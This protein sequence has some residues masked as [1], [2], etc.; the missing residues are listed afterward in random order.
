MVCEQT[1]KGHGNGTDIG[2]GDSKGGC[3]Q[4]DLV[5]EVSDLVWIEDHEP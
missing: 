3:R 1:L 5:D 2:F 4:T